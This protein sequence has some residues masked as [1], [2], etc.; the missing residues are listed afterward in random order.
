MAIITFSSGGMRSS[1]S[2]TTWRASTA[3]TCSALAAISS[4]TPCAECACPLPT[5]RDSTQPAG[6]CDAQC[7][8]EGVAARLTIVVML[9]AVLSCRADL[10]EGAATES[11][12]PT[13][14][15][16]RACVCGWSV[17]WR[18]GVHACLRN[19]LVGT[20]H[21]SGHLRCVCVC[22]VVCVRVR[23]CVCPRLAAGTRPEIRTITRRR[24]AIHAASSQA[25]RAMHCGPA[26]KPRSVAANEQ[27]D[28]A[29]LPLTLRPTA[30]APGRGE[31]VNVPTSHTD[32]RGHAARR[33]A[34]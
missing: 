22:V 4:N 20:M 3:R 13:R 23:L 33:A 15:R 28:V 21:E 7:S 16:S 17:R 25:P 24:A 26:T 29:D 27:P 6:K 34:R 10:L 11:T 30:V 9:H 2:S 31:S 1:P 19:A 5:R 18:V 8:C 32:T 14:L 12:E